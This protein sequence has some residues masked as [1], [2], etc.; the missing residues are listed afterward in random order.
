MKNYVCAIIT[1]GHHTDIALKIYSNRILLII[2]HFKKFGSLV[3][4]TRGP[5]LQQFGGSYNSIKVVF[6]RDDIEV[7]AAAKFIAEQITPDK[8]LLVSISLKDY[9]SDTLKAI[10]A[11][12][13][14]IKPW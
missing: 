4:V 12:I 11:A 9:D 5:I 7:A 13:N 6:G 10:A 1:H 8:P 2:T 3:S 14:E